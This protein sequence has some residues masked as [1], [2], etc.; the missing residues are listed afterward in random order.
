MPC[1]LLVYNPQTKDK[2][3]YICDEANTERLVSD[4]HAAKATG[5]YVDTSGQAF[6]VDWTV[7][8][9]IGFTRRRQDGEVVASGS[10]DGSQSPAC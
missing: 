9:L 4:D 10:A 8:R 3:T 5:E 1:D 6:S 2:K 7:S